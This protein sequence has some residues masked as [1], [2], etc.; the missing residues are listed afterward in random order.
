MMLTTGRSGWRRVVPPAVTV[1]S[2]VPTRVS[3]T[4]K[5]FQLDSTDWSVAPLAVT[6]RSPS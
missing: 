6:T 5:S 4:V 2:G 3:R 1:S